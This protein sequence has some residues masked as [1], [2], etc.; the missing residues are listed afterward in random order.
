MLN[1]DPVACRWC[2]YDRRKGNHGIIGQSDDPE[3]V[4]VTCHVPSDLV[5]ERVVVV[6][7][8]TRFVEYLKD[9][10]LEHLIDG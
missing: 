2:G 9:H 5:A 3:K 4:N 8:R 1:E 6:D 10:K 7:D